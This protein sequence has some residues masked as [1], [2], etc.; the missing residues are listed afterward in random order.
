MTA[1]TL[2]TFVRLLLVPFIV[3]SI[4]EED[5][6]WA[7]G[8]VIAAGA[9]DA[10]DGYIARRFK[11]ASELG[12]HLDAIAD[13]ALLVSLYVM[14]GFK[15][16]LPSWLVILVVFRDVLIIGAVLLARL[17]KNPMQMTPHLLSKVNTLA[18]ILLAVSVLAA[19]AINGQVTGAFKLGY[20]AVGLLTAAS[21]AVYFAAWMRHMT[22]YPQE[23]KS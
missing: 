23:P 1:P 3:W 16:V 10:L 7:L 19:L 15:L 6:D 8:A 11:L 9:S 14:L 18:Q 20:A 4:L 21:G 2:V 5:Y 22:Q 17:L 12:A 13:K